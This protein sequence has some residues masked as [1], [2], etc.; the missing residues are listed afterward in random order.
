M[1]L[2]IHLHTTRTEG[3]ALGNSSCLK[4]Q[5]F[6]RNL[7]HHLLFFVIID[8]LQLRQFFTANLLY[9]L[10]AFLGEGHAGSTEMSRFLAAEAKLF[11]NATFAFFRSE[12]GDLDGIY[13]HGVRVVGLGG[14]GVG[15]RVVGLVGGL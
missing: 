14:R 4:I 1:T 7:S 10:V 2:Q 15:E 5:W 12:L 6:E 8:L 9:L 11:L 13:D 3:F